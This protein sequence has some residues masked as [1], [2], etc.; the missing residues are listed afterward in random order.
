MNDMKNRCSTSVFN[1]FLFILSLSSITEHSDYKNWTPLSGR[2]KCFEKL[3]EYLDLIYPISKDEVKVSPNSLHEFLYYC[4]SNSKDIDT[5]SKNFSLLN[6]R[7]KDENNVLVIDNDFKVKKHSLKDD[8]DIHRLN[9]SIT[10]KQNRNQKVSQSLQINKISEME[11]RSY[12]NHKPINNDFDD[13]S[14]HEVDLSDIDDET[15]INNRNKENSDN[16]LSDLDK[17]E[18]YNKQQYEYFDYVNIN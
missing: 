15:V 17:D 7:K 11:E 4:V 13:K 1:E 8:N 18:Y 2:L 10:M 16:A 12:S 5:Y 14:D 6:M 3:R 9:N